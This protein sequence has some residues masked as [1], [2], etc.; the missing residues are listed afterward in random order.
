M[1]VE[2]LNHLC[3]SII[4]IIFGRCQYPSEFC[5]SEL[6]WY[7][8]CL[9]LIKLSLICHCFLQVFLIIFLVVNFLF[10]ICFS[11]VAMKFVAILGSTFTHLLKKFSFFACAYTS[12]NLCRQLKSRATYQGSLGSCGM[13]T[14]WRWKSLLSWWLLC[15]FYLL[16]LP[17]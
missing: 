4:V 2:F 8:A 5:N 9:Q 13:I 14:R 17:E 16:N 11:L 1:D 10:I 7:C 6:A 3:F 15:M 12:I